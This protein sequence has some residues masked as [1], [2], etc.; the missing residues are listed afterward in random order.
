[1]PS[2][3]IKHISKETKGRRGGDIAN[4]IMGHKI[5]PPSSPNIW[6]LPSLTL[7]LL[8]NLDFIKTPPPSYPKEQVWHYNNSSSKD[9]ILHC[10]DDTL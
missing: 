10:A 9:T 3:L 5:N 2:S 4:H 1:M 7:K 8:F 6:P